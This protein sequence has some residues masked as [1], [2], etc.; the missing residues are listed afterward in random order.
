M[1]L[2]NNRKPDVAYATCGGSKR[3]DRSVANDFI[4]RMS[5]DG[6]DF[7]NFGSSAPKRS[8][9]PSRKAPKKPAKKSFF[10]KDMNL[11]PF[12][13]A[14]IAVV[15]L[16]VIISLIAVACS[17][18]GSDAKI[19]DTVYF[20]YID[21]DNKYHVVVNGD[22][23]SKTFENEIELIPAADNSFAY[24]LEKLE[25]STKMHVLSGKKLKTSN[26]EADKCI[27]FAALEPCIIYSR[28]GSYKCFTD[29]EFNTRIVK[30]KGVADFVISADASAI[31]YTYEKTDSNGEDYK[32]LRYYYD[33]VNTEPEGI[34]NIIPIAISSNGRYVYGQVDE[35]ETNKHAGQLC[36]IDMKAKEIKAKVITSSSTY[37]D[38]GEITAM[39]TNGDE[40]IFYTE[41]DTQ[42]TL[43][44]RFSLKDKKVNYLGKGI[45]KHFSIDS[46]VL[47]PSTFM[48]E[49]FS[50]QNSY[51]DDDDGNNGAVSTYCLKKSG[52]VKVTNAD[53]KFSPDGKYFYFVDEKKSQ[54]ARIP[55]SAKNY[56]ESVEYIL[57][58]DDVKDFVITQKGD[59]YILDGNKDNLVLSFV[60]PSTTK[61]PILISDEINQDSINIC[62]NTVYFSAGVI[63]DEEE[64]TAIFTSTDGGAPVPAEFKSVELTKTPTI[65]MGAGKNGYAYVTDDNDVTML[66]YT[67]GGKKFNLVSD[68]CTLP[69]TQNST[70][71]AI[72]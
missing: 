36:V 49:Y 15:A 32:A 65:G 29:G 50:V 1:L 26:E 63:E 3:D 17:M 14:G 37:G 59:V 46:M 5:T 60:E 42:G 62:S 66:F 41:K 2:K 57:V 53:G 52:T 70:G 25:S 28:N 31:V 7:G 27:S 43:S 4:T 54:L 24:I 58:I 55:L 61:K 34:K 12:V 19:S 11:K 38:F 20:T 44:F 45:F 16:L 23:I 9:R 64:S 6:D 22:E 47:T 51:D 35:N 13:F 48:G 71:S 8:A 21:E 72:G 69:K 67:S 39:N 56:E 33:S 10:N 40:I 68:N 18:P 30:E